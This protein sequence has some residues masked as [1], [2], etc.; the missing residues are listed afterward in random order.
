MVAGE[1]GH[2]V[3]GRALGRRQDPGAPS[4]LAKQPMA[5][6]FAGRDRGRQRNAQRPAP[7]APADRPGGPSARSRPGTRTATRAGAP[8]GPARRLVVGVHV[9]VPGG[10]HRVA[11]RGELA[12]R[13]RRARPRGR[14]RRCRGT[15][16][17]S[18]RRPGRRAP[19]ARRRS[20]RPGAWPARPGRRGRVGRLAVGHRDQPQPAPAAASSAMVPPTPSTSSSGWA[21]RPPAT[22]GQPV[23]VSRREPAQPGPARQ[24][25]L[26]GAGP[27]DHVHACG[28]P[29]AL[30][31]RPARRAGPGPVRRD[32]GAGTRSG[33][34]P[35]GRAP[36]R[37][38]AA[39]PR[40]PAR[41]GP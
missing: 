19:A 28:S 41:P 15:R 23:E 21:A 30:L 9:P 36:R 17:G 31:R 20:R 12:Q 25:A 27:V 35:G 37:G 14:P 3:R 29:A 2:G 1:V 24:R 4:W 26:V 6:P 32:A 5:A 40:A 11:A 16:A 10:Q 7:T 8:G 38:P 13:G 18:R 33:R 22:R 34:R 39:R